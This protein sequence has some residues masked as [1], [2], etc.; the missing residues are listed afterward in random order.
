VGQDPSH[1]HAALTISM[2]RR[3]KR[4]QVHYSSSKIELNNKQMSER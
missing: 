4:Q 2:C 1:H 3:L